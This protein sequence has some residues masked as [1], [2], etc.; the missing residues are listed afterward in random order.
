MLVEILL[1]AFLTILNG[2]LAMSELAVV[3][4]R[5][6]RLKALQDTNVAGARTALALAQDPGRF[7]STVQIGITLVGIL[8]GALSG[9]TLGR[10]LGQWLA[11]QGIPGDI[12]APAGVGTVVVIITYF[13]LIIGELVPK[14]VA[15]RNPERIA[16]LVAPPMQFLAVLTTPVVWL[17]DVSGQLVLKL[18]RQD[19]EAADKVTEEEVRNLIAD[20]E[21]A[22]V[23]ESDER[24]MIAGVMRFADRSAE[25]LETPRRDVEVIDLADDPE[26][27]RK[28]LLATRHA[29]LPVQ[30]GKPD[31]IVGAILVH[32]VM[33]ALAEEQPF[34]PRAHIHKVPVVPDHLDALSMLRA[35]RASSV[36]LALVFDEYGHFEGV[37]T[38]GDILEA[39]TGAF[40]EEGDEEPAL[41]VRKDGSWLVEG[42]MPVDEF[43]AAIGVDLPPREGFETVAGLLLSRTKRLPRVG[44]R[45]AIDPL[46]FEVIDLDGRRIDK[47]LVTRRDGPGNKAEKPEERADRTGETR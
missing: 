38:T 17:L 37:I 46:S 41:V 33:A 3:S 20:A 6:V 31:D 24:S 34:D 42:W 16:A 36:H 29:R 21:S 35:I 1:I 5:P 14:R 43:A 7:L 15:L 32:E 26:E 11:G 18:L 25:G 22:G 30:D 47:V 28:Q 27:I 8:N 4:A 2:L 39:I 10:R 19:G 13:S 23:I 12:A 45:I 9:A 44:E 40:K